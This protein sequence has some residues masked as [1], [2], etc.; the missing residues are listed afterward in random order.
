MDLR[1]F[2]ISIPVFKSK[3][4]IPHNTT[5]INYIQLKV[6]EYLIMGPVFELHKKKSFDFI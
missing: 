6:D 5:F 1:F 3:G 4:N 2:K